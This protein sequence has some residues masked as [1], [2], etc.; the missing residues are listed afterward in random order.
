MQNLTPKGMQD[1]FNLNYFGAMYMIQE[2]VPYIAR[3]GRIINIGA[4]ASLIYVPAH[5]AYGAS[6]AA[7]DHSTKVWAAEVSSYILLNP[8]VLFINTA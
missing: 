4:M 1:D 5:P 6:K 3:G 2:V 7:A 8:R